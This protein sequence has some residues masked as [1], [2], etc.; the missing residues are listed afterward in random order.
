MGTHSIKA[1]LIMYERHVVGKVFIR[2]T[3]SSIGYN[4]EAG[5]VIFSG[6]F[7]TPE[8]GKIDFG[9]TF[10]GNTYDS[11]NTAIKLFNREG[12]EA[13]NFHGDALTEGSNGFSD[14]RYLKA[15]EHTL[16]IHW[17]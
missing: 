3:K 11:V 14:V 5:M 10:K 1:G 16:D 6:L 8:E 15:G 4:H 17:V 2:Y 13:L 9:T 7:K 12:L